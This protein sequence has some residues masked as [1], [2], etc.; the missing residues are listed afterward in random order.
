M[1]RCRTAYAYL[2]H[3][4]TSKVHGA[5]MGPIGDRQDPGGPHV[6]AMNVAIWEGFNGQI[7][8]KK[9]PIVKG[10]APYHALRSSSCGSRVTFTV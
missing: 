2:R 5:I 4:P 1:R 3:N 6:G 10:Y 9:F 8:H 7:K